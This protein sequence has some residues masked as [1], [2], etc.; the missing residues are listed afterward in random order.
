LDDEHQMAKAEL[1]T[2]LNDHL[3]GSVAALELLDH[4]IKQFKGQRLE[5]FFSDLRSDVRSDQNVLRDLIHRLDVEESSV[6]KAGAWLVEKLGR[7]KIGLAKEGAG[8]LQALEGL[9]LGITGKQ[10]LWRA[11]AAVAETSPKLRGIDFGRLEERAIEQIERVE[12][13]RLQAAHAALSA[14]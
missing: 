7:A 6:R 3:A 4:L 5:K 2:H 9:V 8:L 14:G 1:A 10:L 12:A 13:E 11:M